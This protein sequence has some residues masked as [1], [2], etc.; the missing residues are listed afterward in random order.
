MAQGIVNILEAIQVYVQQGQRQVAAVAGAHL[1]FE[2][3]QEQ[4][5]IGQAG[6]NL[7]KFACWMNEDD[8]ASGRGGTGC[9][10]GSKNLKAIVIKA[11]KKI[12]KAEDRESW[13]KAHKRA[14][15][16]IMAEENILVA[17]AARFAHLPFSVQ[18]GTLREIS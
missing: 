13:K 8:R 7:V 11:K 12:T 4:V 6:E 17:T 15:K 2:L 18:C 14:L 1:V 5:T 16:T 9:V 10:G 3:L